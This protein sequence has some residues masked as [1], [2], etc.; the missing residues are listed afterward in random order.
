[1]K[2]DTK[3]HLEHHK[4]L[5]CV[6][7]I[8]FLVYYVTCVK[9]LMWKSMATFKRD[10]YPPIISLFIYLCS[11]KVCILDGF[12]ALGVHPVIKFNAAV[13]VRSADCHKMF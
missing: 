12:S 2:N 7:I 11:D 6:A 8:L 1:M 3:V 13:F 10:H 4:F 9:A 5:E